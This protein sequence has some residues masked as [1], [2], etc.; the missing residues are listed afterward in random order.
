MRRKYRGPPPPP[1]RFPQV[2]PGYRW[3]GVDRGNGFEAQ[4]LAKRANEADRK[5]KQHHNDSYDM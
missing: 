4:W 2:K 3:D 5:Q 1:T